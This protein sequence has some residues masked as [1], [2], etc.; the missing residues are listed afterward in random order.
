MSQLIKE[1]ISKRIK[2][3]RLD[4]GLTQAKLA[5][6]TGIDYKYIQKIEG[7]NPP[8]FRVGTLERI[9]KALKVPVSQIINF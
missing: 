2:E 4:K 9:A 3:L 7:K 1:K 6:V 5:E 8:D